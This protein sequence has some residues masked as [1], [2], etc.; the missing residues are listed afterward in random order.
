VGSI[1]T[2]VAAVGTKMASPPIESIQINVM[3][4]NARSS[5]DVGSIF[6]VEYS[7]LP[8]ASTSY[9]GR[10]VGVRHELDGEYVGGVPGRHGG[11]EHERGETVVR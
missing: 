11:V 8:I 2:V 5:L 3:A 7:H 9:Q 10:V 4:A 1:H 6:K